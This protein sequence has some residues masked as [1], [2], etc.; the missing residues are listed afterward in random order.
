MVAGP[1]R[2]PNTLETEKAAALALVADLDAACTAEPGR[3]HPD[4]VALLNA[5]PY[6]RL[7]LADAPQ[8]LLRA[9]FEAPPHD[10]PA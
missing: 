6:L 2:G 10:Q 4:D 1:P 9:L 7:N 3:P 8:P 5:L